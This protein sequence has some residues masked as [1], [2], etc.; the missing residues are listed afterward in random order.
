MTFSAA[1]DSEGLL[2]FEEFEQAQAM[3][4]VDETTLESEEALTRLAAGEALVF[5]P[6]PEDEEEEETR[7]LE[8]F[9]KAY[10][11]LVPSEYPVNEDSTLLVL[12]MYPSGSQS[13]I[14]YLE[15]LFEVYRELIASM[16]P[17]SYHPDMEVQ[18]GGRLKRHLNELESIMNDVFNSFATGFSGVVLLV[19]FYFFLKK[20]FNYR[21]GRAEDLHYSVWAHLLRAP[22]PILVIGIPLVISLIWTFGIT[23]A[24]LGTLNTMT[25]VL[26]VILFGLG[27]DYGIHFYARY[28]ELRSD[29]QDVL[30]ALLNAYERTGAAIIVSAVTTASALFVLIFADFRGFSE[31]GFISGT[32]ILLALFSML[33]ILPS[34]LTLFEKMNWILLTKRSEKNGKLRLMKRYPF[35]RL[36]VTLSLLLSAVIL[37]NVTKLYFE[38]QFGEL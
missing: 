14:S 4:P 27:I 20:Y 16:N 17:A 37:F 35:S 9:Q 15:D 24:V 19:L 18:F 38:Y 3:P 31:F 1:R 34:L 12:Q 26:F 36:I 11:E 6:E 8:R 2:T 21:K 30:P 7:D 5:E 32:G 28:I 10:D 33:F 23:Y 22:I 29:G 13:D 25:S